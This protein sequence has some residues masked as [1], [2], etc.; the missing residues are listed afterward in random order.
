MRR[1]MRARGDITCAAAITLTLLAASP[2]RG[3]T[4]GS[5]PGEG[6]ELTATTTMAV[7]PVAYLPLIEKH[8]APTNTPTTTVPPLP[9]P[10]MT[11]TTTVPSLPQPSAT[12]VLPPPTLNNC[13][14]DPNPTAAPNY[15]VRIVDIDKQAETVT[16]RNVTTGDT[17]DLS[18]WTMCSITGNQ[19]HPVG[20]ILGPGQTQVFS[21]PA[22]SIWNNSASDPGALYNEQGQLVSYWP[23]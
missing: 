15:P 11:P 23:D 3:A 9:E 10:S 17:I 1:A 22:G 4:G 7:E 6:I 20:G 5:R 18:N 12:P 2:F 14:G 21:G 13:Q 8:D 19:R 16:L